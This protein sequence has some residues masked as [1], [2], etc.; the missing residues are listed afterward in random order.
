MNAPMDAKAQSGGIAPRD[1]SSPAPQALA[2]SGGA[3]T[4]YGGGTAQPE[5]AFMNPTSM[6][7]KGL[8]VIAVFVG[9]SIAWASLAPLESS[10][11]APGVIV[12]ET[13]RKT[14]Q[15]LEGGIVKD[16]LVTEGQTVAAG[17]PLLRLEETQAQSN[18]NLLQDQ[19]N[20]LIAQ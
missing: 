18:F 4:P 14:I 17:Q 10:V 2:A 12:V 20:A 9:G 6:I 13:H 8:L 15:H 1:A 7:R 11:T 5:V 16:V 3:L 19:A